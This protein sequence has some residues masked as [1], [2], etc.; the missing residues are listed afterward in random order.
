VGEEVY[1]PL[2]EFECIGVRMHGD[3]RQL[4]H[5][6]K[7]HIKRGLTPS[8]PTIIFDLNHVLGVKWYDPGL[9]YTAGIDVHVRH[10]Q[11]VFYFRPGARKLL[12]WCLS[13]TA[14][15]VFVWSTAQPETVEAFVLA[16]LP[17]F[18]RHQILSSAHLSPEGTKDPSRIGLHDPAQLLAFD[19]DPT[20]FPAAYRARVVHVKRFDPTSPFDGAC[21][22]DRVCISMLKEIVRPSALVQQ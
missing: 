3:E 20:K 14:A 4:V 5:R 1:D 15:R 8:V 9:A 16:M 10:K 2:F 19:D 7:S 21:T 11:L 22:L 17:V 12:Q 18:P 6:A 13:H